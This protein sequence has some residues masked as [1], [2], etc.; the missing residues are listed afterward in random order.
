ME[1]VREA[2]KIYQGV[3]KHAV[4][5]SANL[6]HFSEAFKMREGLSANLRHLPTTKCVLSRLWC[7]FEIIARE[8][9]KKEWHFCFCV[10]EMFGNWEE[11]GNLIETE[12]RSFFLLQ[13]FQENYDFFGKVECFDNN[14][15]QILGSDLL[16]TFETDREFNRVVGGVLG[17]TYLQ[18]FDVRH[19]PAFQRLVT[20]L[21]STLAP[22]LTHPI[23]VS[24]EYPSQR[25]L[26]QGTSA[27][28]QASRMHCDNHAAPLSSINEQRADYA[29]HGC[30][31]AKHPQGCACAI[32]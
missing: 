11:Y 29:L 18:P 26:I 23:P 28:T 17:G 14:D 8:Y 32:S 9:E 25:A 21:I 10:A 6:N 15:H 1:K 7:L 24:H 3:P 31:S 13:C 30:S 4:L 5:A 20:G 27:S 2:K 16:N 22:P 19:E 12:S